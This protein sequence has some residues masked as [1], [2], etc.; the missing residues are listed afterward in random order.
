MMEN[1]IGSNLS[2][3]TAG[4]VWCAPQGAAEHPPYPVI[5]NFAMRIPLSAITALALAGALAQSPRAAAA[6]D[7]TAP[8]AAPSAPSAIG[9][10]DAL[11]NSG[12]TATGYVDAAYEYS[13]SP[14]PAL[15]EF[16]TRHSSFVLDQASVTFAMQPK[17]G[18]GFVVDLIAGEDGRVINEA[19]STNP[20]SGGGDFNVTQAFVQYVDPYRSARRIRHERSAHFHSRSE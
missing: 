9:I 8:A 3:G 2:P 6:D 19:E 17:T 10:L 14:V 1:K 12:I 16:D 18:F 4:S 11:A 7:T 15:H 5:R 20:A 13:N